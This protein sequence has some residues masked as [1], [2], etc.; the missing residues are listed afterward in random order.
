M[1][2]MG[3]AES[4]HAQKIA[5]DKTRFVMVKMGDAESKHSYAFCAWLLCKN[6][7]L[8]DS[9]AYVVEKI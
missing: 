9:L 1:V 2:K 3:D 6:S 4:K 8:P 7:M 5:I